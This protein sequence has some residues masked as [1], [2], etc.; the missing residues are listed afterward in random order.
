MILSDGGDVVM[1]MPSSLFPPE[2][3][4]AY[5][6]SQLDADRREHAIVVMAQM[7]FNWVKT[8]STHA[9]Q[10]VDDAHT[11]QSDQASQ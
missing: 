8:H 6:W 5:V 4:A 9:Q 11:P 2:L 1:V 3:D 7:A 10:E